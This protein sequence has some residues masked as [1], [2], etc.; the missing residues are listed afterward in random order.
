MLSA[1]WSRPA[2]RATA[3]TP[4]MQGDSGLSA[5]SLIELNIDVALGEGNAGRRRPRGSRFG[6]RPT[7]LTPN[8]TL[9]RPFRVG[10]QFPASRPRQRPRGRLRPE[11][12]HATHDCGLATAAYAKHNSRWGR[13]NRIGPTARPV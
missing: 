9:R 8:G 11:L 2:I 7:D 1:W 5:A 3:K 6:Y 13:P 10:T 12:G 4:A